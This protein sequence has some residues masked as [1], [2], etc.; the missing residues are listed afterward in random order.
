MSGLI[1]ELFN[2]HVSVTKR[3]FCFSNTRLQ[4]FPALGNCVSSI[5]KEESTSNMQQ[6]VVKIFD[7]SKV[8]F[9]DHGMYEE[10]QNHLHDTHLKTIFK[11]GHF[12]HNSHT[13]SSPS[14]H[15]FQHHRQSMFLRKRSSFRQGYLTIK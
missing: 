9:I 3:L 7:S 8:Q 1:Q 12:L 2:K 13:S 11:L 14:V 15:C 10:F 6:I 4:N 5:L